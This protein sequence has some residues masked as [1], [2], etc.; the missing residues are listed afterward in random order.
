[1]SQDTLYIKIDENV[2]VY[3][4]KVCLKDISEMLCTNQEMENKIRTLKLEHAVGEEA[5]RYVKSVLDVIAC[6]Q[7]EFP[8]LQIQNIGSPEFIITYEKDSQSSNLLSWVKTVLVCILSF[9]GAGFSIMT[10]NNDVDVSGLFR[11]IYELFTGQS[12]DG[13]TIL[14]LSYSMGIGIGIILF[15]NHF[16]GKKLSADPT[17]LEVQMRLYEDD[18]NQTI[19]EQD[20]Q[21]LSKKGYEKECQK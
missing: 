14:E 3:D 10:F 12:S 7:K 8:N 5:G 15:F 19:M 9:F 16:V 13:F 4:R 11:Q 2:Q 6:I 1:M 17:P 18:V 21:K 20:K